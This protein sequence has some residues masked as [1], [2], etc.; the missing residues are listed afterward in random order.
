MCITSAAGD[1]N[2]MDSLCLQGCS[3][4][5]TYWNLELVG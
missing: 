3:S 1:I 5:D 4:P 2:H